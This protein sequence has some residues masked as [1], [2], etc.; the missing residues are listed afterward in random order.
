MTPCCNVILLVY[1]VVDVVC[2]QVEAYYQRALTIYCKK[3]GTDDPN[4]SKTKNNLV[5]SVLQE[6]CTC[7]ACEAQ[8]A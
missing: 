5:S 2:T 3:L 7:V 6:K 4:V 8:M 1:D